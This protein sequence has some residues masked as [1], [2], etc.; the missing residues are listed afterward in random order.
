ML[1]GYPKLG[2]YGLGH[3]LIA[4]ARC[5]VW[6]EQTGSPM[7]APYW[8]KPR[9]GPYLRRE[10]DKREYFKL[11][12]N[13]GAIR[14]PARAW[15][16][17]TSRKITGHDG[18]FD[19]DIFSEA[20]LSRHRQS[21]K[22]TV[23]VFENSL[24]DNTEKHFPAIQPHADLVRRRLLQM[25]RPGY[26]PQPVDR[27]FVAV[28]VRLGDFLQPADVAD[29]GMHSVRRPAS[30][31]RDALVTLRQATGSNTKA[32]V[33]SDGHDS[34]I[35]ELLALPDV[36]RAP[37]RESI[38]DMLEMSQARA[39]IGTSSGFSFWAAFLGQVPR[40]SYPGSMMTRALTDGDL[41][42]ELVSG[43]TLPEAF[44][45]K[46]RQVLHG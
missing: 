27:P 4:W 30:W 32:I 29:Q 25:V 7:L 36:E 1:Y 46:V 18:F 19:E 26:F 16:L 33:Y 40:I 37:K 11:F 8:L 38:T 12:N 2:R 34:E 15:H 10:H 6:S 14:E 3:S 43:G 23:L 5:V 35:A 9:L 28:H 39:L 22:K 20:F 13:R 31:Y 44:S 24:T 21:G 42:T 45:H 41:E 17:A